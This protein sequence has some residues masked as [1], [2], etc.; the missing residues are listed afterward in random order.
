MSGNKQI[1][2]WDSNIYLAW[3]RNEQ[4]YA[5]HLPYIQ[6]I[7]EANFAGE[8]TIITSTITLIE[9]LESQ[10][11]DDQKK[12]FRKAFNQYHHLLLDVTDPIARQARKF[13]EFYSSAEDGRRLLVPDAIHLATAH[14]Y[15]V[16]EVHT[17]DDGR[18]K[19]YDE[20][21]EKVKTVSLL[22]MNGNV[23]L[24]NIKICKPFIT[25]AKE[26]PTKT[27]NQSEGDLFSERAN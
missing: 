16:T 7:I 3:L 2:Y 9:V 25:M 19:G 6:R 26:D 21:H 17:F 24:Q 18:K 8:N 5:E 13:R 27:E 1:F 23:A 10:L 15:K 14:V 12:R 11:N 4:T 20:N 22:S